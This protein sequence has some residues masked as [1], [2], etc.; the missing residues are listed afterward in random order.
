MRVP[1]SARRSNLSIL[2]K[3]YPEH[4]LLKLKLQKSLILRKIE[5]K[6]G[7]GR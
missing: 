7:R 5:G 1:L 4:S 6:R 3:I 2:K